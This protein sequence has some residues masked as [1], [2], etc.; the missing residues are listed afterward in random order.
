M[1]SFA[2]CSEAIALLGILLVYALP[3]N[4]KVGRLVGYSLT[5]ASATG[6]V[7]ILSLISSN[8]AGY[9]KSR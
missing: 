8:I 6:F 5:G 9:T 7:V 3:D 2:A 4:L 1:N